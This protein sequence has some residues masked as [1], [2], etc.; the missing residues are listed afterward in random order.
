VACLVAVVKQPTSREIVWVVVLLF[1]L[2][3]GIVFWLGVL[4]MI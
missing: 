1:L 4:A 2:A 3:F